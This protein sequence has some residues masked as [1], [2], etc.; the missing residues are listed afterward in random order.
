MKI[1]TKLIASSAVMIAG[2]AAISFLAIY[3]LGAIRTSVNS[4][5]SHSTPLQI[6]TTELQKIV[7]GLSGNLL[8]LG[9][10]SGSNEVKH[11]SDQINENRKKL[12]AV[13]SDIGRLDSSRSNQREVSATFTTLHGT[14]QNAVETRLKNIA[15][16][17]EDT[18]SVDSSLTQVEQAL[19]T[20]RREMATLNNAG[21]ARVTGAV[22]SSS[23]LFTTSGTVKDM[24]LNL[25]EVQVALS[26]L[27]LAKNRVETA[28][29]RQKIR[30][31]NGSIQ[32]VALDDVQVRDVK[33]E[34]NAIH[35][36][37]VKPDEGLIALKVEI[38]G[39]KNV[40]SKY[41]TLKKNQLN[42]LTELNLK[43]SGLL[44]GMENRVTR[45]R[46][47]VDAALGVRQKITT[48]NDH[49]NSIIGDSRALESKT[50]LLM[51][52][53]NETAYGTAVNGV[54]SLQVRLKSAL[55]GARKELAAIQ[56]VSLTRSMDA[57]VMAFGRSEGSINR[58][59]TTQKN[60]LDSTAVVSKAVTSVKES[61]RKEVQAGE[62]LVKET[63][64]PG[65]NG[66]QHQ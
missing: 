5:T 56:Q 28:G 2:L 43:L 11:L 41:Q 12:D 48:I 30:S 18:A 57:A 27:E 31:I 66:G 65:K 54:R 3:A 20:V 29:V 8:Q 10:S 40:E 17:R 15:L 6:K 37:F 22:A 55:L 53:D 39:G 9:V 50:R 1:R 33:K 47:E 52:S 4:L 46:S 16:F 35:D 59:I 14:V 38:L 7:E 26:N 24:M 36:V 21:S 49:V 63:S 60:I 19:V 45:N 42:T 58:I 64:Q 25:R 44:D 23:Q 62:S 32:A 34:M 13:I 51:L 61:T